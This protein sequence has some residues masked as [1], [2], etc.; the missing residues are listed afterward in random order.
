M[1]IWAK[2]FKVGHIIVIA[3]SILMMNSKYTRLSII[4]AP[5]AIINQFTSN[6]CFSYR[7]ERWFKCFFRCFIHTGFRTVFSIMTSM[8]DKFFKAMMA[9]KFSLAF[10]S[11]CNIVARCG[12]VFSFI[13][14]RRNMR[15]WIRANK[16]VS[17]NFN[18]GI[19]SLTAARTIF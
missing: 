12:T 9:G 13:T 11:L 4:A 19:F 5:I 2:N 10:I 8:T 18:S 7:G 15:K 14:S 6:H 16:T 1:A 3:I 17:L